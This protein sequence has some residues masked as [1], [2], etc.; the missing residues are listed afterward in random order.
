[1]DPIDKTTPQ[2]KAAAL[3]YP[4]VAA[5]HN[6]AEAFN[7]MWYKCLKCGHQERIWNSRDGVTPFGTGCP[8]CGRPDLCHAYMGSDQYSPDYKPHPG[9]R[10]WVT[11]SK[12]QVAQWAEEAIQRG[13]AAGFKTTPEE[14]ERVRQHY[15]SSY[16]D[17][18]PALAIFGYEEKP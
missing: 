8:S 9:Q 17:G 1:M 12:E 2:W 5:G 3:R 10:I 11:A 7:L 18:E 6:H 14:M 4:A 15:L 13:L 16:T